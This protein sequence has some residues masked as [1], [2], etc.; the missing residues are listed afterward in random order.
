MDF[1]FLICCMAVLFF[2]GIAVDSGS[3]NTDI[4]TKCKEVKPEKWHRIKK[5]N[6]G[7]K[8]ISC[9]ECIIHTVGG[10]V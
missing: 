8:F 9:Q 1:S 3:V 2:G 7:C 5:T 4:D 10:Q 6:I